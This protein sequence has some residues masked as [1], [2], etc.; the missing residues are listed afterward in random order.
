MSDLEIQ[1]QDVGDFWKEKMPMMTMEEL[2]ELIQAISKFQRSEGG[3]LTQV[4]NDLVKE[5]ADVYISIHALMW[6]YTDNESMYDCFK[7]DIMAA[8]V[9]KLNKKY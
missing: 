1:M 9:E 6:W 2:A 5:M 7:D 8:V 4:Y 3:D